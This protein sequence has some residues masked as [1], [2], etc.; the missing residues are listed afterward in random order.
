MPT[1]QA[2]LRS[3]LKKRDPRS[4]DP[5]ILQVCMRG[6]EERK[7]TVLASSRKRADFLVRFMKNIF[8]F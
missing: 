4:Q 1:T 7:R 2:H 8:I 3:I 6:E 5:N